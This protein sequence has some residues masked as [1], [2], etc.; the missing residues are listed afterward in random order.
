MDHLL[1][2]LI[3]SVVLEVVQ[4]SGLTYLLEAD[5]PNL[6]LNKAVFIT[7]LY[8]SL[9]VTFEYEYTP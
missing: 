8:V 2:S 4:L 1:V 6:K 9:V 5:P 3:A 7:Y